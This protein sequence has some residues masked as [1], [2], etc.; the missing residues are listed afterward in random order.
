VVAGA[1]DEDR[2]L[3]RHLADVG[4]DRGQDGQARALARRAHD[5]EAGRHL[6]DRLAGLAA[7]QVVR[8]RE[9][10]LHPGTTTFLNR[11]QPIIT[12]E[13]IEGIENLRS[14]LVSGLVA[15]FLAWRWYR[16]RASVG[17]ERFLDDV[18]RIELEVFELH[19][20]RQLNGDRA[21]QLEQRLSQLKSNALEQFSSGKLRGEEQLWSFL[22]HVSDVRNCLHWLAANSAAMPAS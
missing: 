3:V 16:S 12:G 18:T 9:Y 20:G 17:F 4:L 14:F 6:D 19:R 8:H 15:L 22:N 21:L 10:A 13:L 1:L 11:N 5:E 2:H 7:E